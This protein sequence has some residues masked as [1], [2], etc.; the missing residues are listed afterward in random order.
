MRRG[1]RRQRREGMQKRADDDY[2]GG[3]LLVPVRLESGGSGDPDA[4][5][6]ASG[7]PASQ[8]RPRA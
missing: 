8:E 7:S 6:Q 4:A 5:V 2:F 1:A 3:A